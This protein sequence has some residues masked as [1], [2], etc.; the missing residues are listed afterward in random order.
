[1]GNVNRRVLRQV[2]KWLYPGMGVKRWALVIGLSALLLIVGL[3]GLIGRENLRMISGLFSGSGLALYALIAGLSIVGLGGVILGVN[4]LVRSI[5]RGISPEFEGRA[6]EVIYSKRLLSRGPHI[7]AVGGG[8]GLSTLLRGV[9][10]LTSNI[11]A[12]VTVMD[13]GGSSGRLRREMNILPPGDI[14]NC[15]IALAEDE[16]KMAQ[17]FQHRF[18]TGGGSA[19]NGHSLGNLVLA[20]LQEMT[21]S[22]DRAIEELSSLLNVRGQ[23]LPATL[24]DVQLVA[25]L[26]DGSLARGEFDIVQTKKGIV[27]MS[28]SQPRVRPYPKVLAA[29]RSADLIILGPGSLFTSLIPNLLVDEV[30]R[31]IEL[32]RAIKFHIANLMTQP[33]ETEGFTLKDHLRV[34]NDYIDLTTFDC[35]VVNR[36]AIPQDLQERY[37]L[38]KASPVWNDLDAVNEYALEVVESDLLD[39]VELEGKLTVKHHPQKLSQVIARCAKQAFAERLRRF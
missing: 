27:R 1:M 24:E 17:L 16:S 15:L 26:A 21:G 6:S 18:R 22:F 30:A 39:I 20:G 19:L 36:E 34:L 10:H 25:E 38:E 8:T 14:R 28:L 32:S 29:I 23:V 2:A 9:K 7:V 13:D 12:I 11:T 4:Q 33:G 3:I 35:V 31:E 37:R 5:I